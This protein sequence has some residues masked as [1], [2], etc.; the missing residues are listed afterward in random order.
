MKKI[1]LALVVCL[2]ASLGATHASAQSAAPG[3][4][5][6]KQR[7]TAQR[8]TALPE[9]KALADQFARAAAGYTTQIRIM[10]GAKLEDGGK[11]L[12]PLMN[13]LYFNAVD[14]SDEDYAKSRFVLHTREL[15][16][17]N[18]QVNRAFAG[19][20]K[21][22]ADLAAN[23]LTAAINQRLEEGEKLYEKYKNSFNTVTENQDGSFN[24][25]PR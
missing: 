15:A 4:P 18:Q 16:V 10:Q 11:K 13:W 23:A 9:D 12:H 6:V 20:D 24:I 3:T 19:N 25:Q 5:D 7:R 1:A 21:E 8:P 17:L 22:K 14:L 2:F